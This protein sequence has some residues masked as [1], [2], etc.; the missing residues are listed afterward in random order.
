MIN[1]MLRRILTAT[2]YNLM[3]MGNLFKKTEVVKSLHT[4]TKSK[5]LEE[6]NLESIFQTNLT[7]ED[8]IFP[9]MTRDSLYYMIT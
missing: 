3:N 7:L 8:P 2:Q 5:K 6:T 4:T 1:K 9:K